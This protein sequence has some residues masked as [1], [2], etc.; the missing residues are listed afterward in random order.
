MASAWVRPA[1]ASRISFIRDAEIEDTIRVFASPLFLAAGLEP[2]AVHIYLVNDRALNAFVAGGQRLFVNTGLIIRTEH[3]GQLIGVIAHETGHIA[4][5]H[6]VR[7]RE[8]VANATAT[9]IVAMILGGIAAAGAGHGDGVGAAILGGQSA[10]MRSFFQYSRTQESSADH[11]GMKFLDDNGWSAVGLQE[12]FRVLE[13]QDL[14][15]TDRQDPYMRTHPLTRER[16]DRVAEHIQKSPFTKAAFPKDFD[17]RHRRMRAKLVAFMET[18]GTALRLYKETDNSL[19]SR[20][21]RTVAYY[22]KLE[23]D[24]AH[25]MID[26]LIAENPGDPYFHE[27]KGQMLFEKGQVAESLAPYRMAVK[28]MPS[29]P[30]LR[31]DLAKV[32]LELEDPKQLDE[33]IANLQMALSFDKDDPSNWRRLAIAYGRKGDEGMSALALGEEALLQNKPDIAKFQAVKAEKLLPHGSR[34]WL[35]AQD[36]LQAA[37]EKA[38]AKDR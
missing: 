25:Q 7:T 19:E 36:V 35:Q 24:K 37:D 12:F 30:L 33:A 15:S 10:G 4:G 17:V 6:L 1:E 27:L 31:A 16:I 11:A 38:K 21:A 32:Q 3:P 28:L 8:A 5:G 14:L 20:Y 26:G 2:S 13:G 18:P 34:A 23:L 9:Q 22:R 29:S